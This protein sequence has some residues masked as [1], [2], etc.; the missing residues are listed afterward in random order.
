MK[1]LYGLSMSICVRDVVEGKHDLERVKYIISSDRFKTLDEAIS[2]YKDSSYWEKNK[3]ACIEVCMK[4]WNSGRIIQPRVIFG[5]DYFP[6]TYGLKDLWVEGQEELEEVLK[7]HGNCSF[8]L[9]E[10]LKA[11]GKIS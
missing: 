6:H 8:D 3:E 2:R 11:A 5:D 1:R 7:P 4:L 9:F 10:M